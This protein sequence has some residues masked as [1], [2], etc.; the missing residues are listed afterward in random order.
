MQ[1]NSIYS[2][3][4]DYEMPWIDYETYTVGVVTILLLAKSDCKNLKKSF[5]LWAKKWD[6]IYIAVQ[7]CMHF[8]DVTETGMR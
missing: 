3:I 1:K 2:D 7:E 6:R 4:V 8:I 5:C